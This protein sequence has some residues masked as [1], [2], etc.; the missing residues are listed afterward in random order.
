MSELWVQFDHVFVGVQDLVDVSQVPLLSNNNC[1]S[2]PTVFLRQ[3][4]W[5]GQRQ[6]VPIQRNGREQFP[7]P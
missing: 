6:G 5:E 7:T 3:T 1:A 2:P 4:N